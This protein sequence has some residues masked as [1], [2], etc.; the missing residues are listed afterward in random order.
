MAIFN[1]GYIKDFFNKKKK[2]DTKYNKESDKINENKKANVINVKLFDKNIFD[3]L[4]HNE[5]LTAE[6]III[7]DNNCDIIEKWFRE[8]NNCTSNNLN[9][10]I[11]TGKVMN[12][13]YHLTTDNK[14]P[15]N[16]FKI[17][18]IDWITA[19]VRS[20]FKSKWRW[21]SDVV[22]N[23]AKREIAKRNPYYK[24][25]NSIYYGDIGFED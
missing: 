13:F 14:Y 11:I 15:E 7:K 4:Y 21:F 6:G 23:N 3:K 24:H 22:D 20:P 25:Y 16:N 18:C 1:E 5:A 12:D 17:L 10:Y 9:M 2:E 8:R 19:G